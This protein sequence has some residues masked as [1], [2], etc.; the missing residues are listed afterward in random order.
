MSRP[1]IPRLNRRLCSRKCIPNRIFE[2]WGFLFSLLEFLFSIFR[3]CRAEL[4]GGEALESAKAFGKF[5]G[6]QATLAVE[7]A[8]EVLSGTLALRGVAFDAAG[9][10]IAVG[11][12]LALRLRDDMIEATL[13][14]SDA[15][16]AVK[17]RAAVAS[18]YG[19]T[20]GGS[21]HEI[22]LFEVGAAREAG[23]GAD[24]GLVRAG[25]T[26]L[27]GQAHLDDVAFFA[28]LQQLQYAFTSEPAQGLANG[29]VTK[30]KIASQ[31][32]NGKTQAGLPFQAGL[33]EK[34]GIDGAL[35]W[36]KMQA[37]RQEVLELLP[38]EFGIGLFG[39]HDEILE[40]SSQLTVDSS[41]HRNK[42]K[43]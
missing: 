31:P 5:G 33:P 7:P 6:G 13:A 20:Q 21:F 17:A 41:Q 18:V 40:R 25:A 42:A 38:G 35:G 29:I 4:A 30:A 3:Q 32:A 15:A 37:R 19:L 22:D 1:S 24:L 23:S 16:Q 27:A 34:V 12:E 26:N 39:F 8:K 9:D 2:R 28:A 14:A 36:G 43:T 10:E 11:V